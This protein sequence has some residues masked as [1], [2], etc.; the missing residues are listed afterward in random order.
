MGT[1]ISRCK[2]ST[3][4]SWLQQES[5]RLPSL[6]QSTRKQPDQGI[7]IVFGKQTVVDCAIGV[8]LAPRCKCGSIKGHNPPGAPRVAANSHPIGSAWAVQY[9]LQASPLQPRRKERINPAKTAQQKQDRSPSEAERIEA[10][11][12]G[13]EDRR[14]AFG[15]LLLRSSRAVLVSS[16][17]QQAEG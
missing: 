11:C 13:K 4:P 12:H 10:G 9:P 7:L 15:K 8:R 3:N 17:D 14:E 2:S 1:P 5:P 6:S 16:P